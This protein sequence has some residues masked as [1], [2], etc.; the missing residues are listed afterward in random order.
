MDMTEKLDLFLAEVPYDNFVSAIKVCEKLSLPI[1]ENEDIV[2]ALENEGEI[3]SQKDDY[4][5]PNYLVKRVA[6][7]GAETSNKN[8]YYILGVTENAT[9][10][11]IKSAYRKLATKFHPD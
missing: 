11:E 9:E 5:S 7:Y 6:L 4:G 3:I 1:I 8:Y 10:I 2:I